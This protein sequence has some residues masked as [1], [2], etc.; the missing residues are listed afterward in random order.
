MGG[1]SKTLLRPSDAQAR[2]KLNQSHE[3]DPQNWSENCKKLVPKMGP[4]KGTQDLAKT[5]KTQPL[6]LKLSKEQPKTKLGF[7]R[8]LLGS[9][10]A[11]LGSLGSPWAS[12]G[13]PLGSL[14]LPLASLG[15]LLGPS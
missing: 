12:P 6:S 4:E 10:W 14:G 2:K 3:N 11:L 13:P 9:S 1:P 15:A 8:P 7:L 5:K